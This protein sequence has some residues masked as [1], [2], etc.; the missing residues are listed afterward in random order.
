MNSLALMISFVLILAMIFSKVAARYG[1]P[2]LL[3]FLIM[4]MLFGSEGLFKIPFD[5]Y[6]LASQI[7]SYALMLIIFYGGFSLNWSKAFPVFK[8]ALLLSTLATFFTALLCGLFCVIVLNM[9]LW[10]GLLV[11]A[12]LSSTDAASVFSI[13]K[14]HNLN[15]KDHLAS[16]LEMESGSND[17][18]AYLLTIF[19]IQMMTHQEI[20]IIDFIFSQ[21]LVGLLVGFIVAKLG[22]WV[23]NK[24]Q[25]NIDGLYPIFVLGLVLLSFEIC[26]KFNGNGYICVYVI[27]III[28][29]HTFPHKRFT[30]H[31]FDGLSW[32]MQIALFFTLGLLSYPSRLWSHL[33][34]GLLIAFFITCVARPLACMLVLTPL[35]FN[36]KKQILIDAVG[37]RGA[38]SIAFSIMAVSSIPKLE[39]DLFH[40]VFLVCFFSVLI[41]GTLLPNLAKKLDLVEPNESVFKTFNDYEEGHLAML[42]E[43]EIDSHHEWCN[44]KIKEAKIPSH[45]LIV[46]VKRNKQ[47]LF[48]KGNLCLLDQDCIILTQK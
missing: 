10:E 20:T 11:G 24:I 26:N 13:L 45:L 27:G 23:L 43:I 35:K 44:K 1:V 38:A 21:L 40:I 15:F 17:P 8:P 47:M 48:P 32:L 29:N 41:Q 9:S 46:G 2:S 18:I 31:F 7:C 34:A 3:L 33:G 30:L 16:L 37:F 42:Y 6:H 25:L 14:S 39:N 4:G 12:V 5:D 36:Y 22:D 19:C 28:G